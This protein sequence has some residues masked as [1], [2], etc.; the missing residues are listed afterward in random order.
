MTRPEHLSPTVAAQQP[1]HE[2]TKLIQRCGGVVGIV[3]IPVTADLCEED[4]AGRARGRRIDVTP[5]LLTADNMT[6]AWFCAHEVGHLHYNRQHPVLTRVTSR[7]ALL[8]GQAALLVLLAL[9]PA[10]ATVAFNPAAGAALMVVSGAAMLLWA[11]AWS[12]NSRHEEYQADRA[13]VS[14]LHALG[15]DPAAVAGHVLPLAYVLPK[16]LRGLQYIRATHPAAG[17]RLRH[18][19]R[20]CS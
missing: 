17:N 11:F 18:V 10:I 20:E 14:M 9:S 4:P 7:T 6:Q 16:T 1:L 8:I 12:A 5:A 3:D 19:Q 15:Y 2:V 13:A